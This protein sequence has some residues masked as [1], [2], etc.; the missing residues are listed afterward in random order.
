MAD[1]TLKSFLVALGFRIDT[2]GER[3]F[4]DTIGNATKR[5]AELGLGIEAMALAVVGATKRVANSFEDMYYMSSRIGSSVKDIGAFGYA[6]S[7]L[8]GSKEA[9][10]QTLEELGKKLRTIPGYAAQLRNR[11]IDPNQGAVA[12]AKEFIQKSTKGMSYWQSYMWAQNFSIDERTMR[13]AMDKNFNKFWDEYNEKIRRIGLDPKKAAEDAKGFDQAW[14]SLGVT[15]DIIGQK[16]TS[17]LFQG[18]GKDFKGFSDF[19]LENSGQ[20]T[21]AIVKLGDA[22]I[23]FSEAVVGLLT[24]G[25][26]SKFVD[27]LTGLVKWLSGGDEGGQSR[28]LTVFEG[29]LAA[30]VFSKLNMLIGLLDGVAVAVRGFTAAGLALAASPFGMALTALLASTTGL[31]EGEQADVDA[32]KGRGPGKNA[33]E[34]AKKGLLPGFGGKPAGKP[35]SFWQ[36]LHKRFGTLPPDQDPD[37][38]RGSEMSGGWPAGVSFGGENEPFYKSVLRALREWWSE[39]RG[40]ARLMRSGEKAAVAGAL[41]A[42]AAFVP[43]VMAGEVL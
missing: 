7:Q 28:L 9:A 41:A 33:A 13:A 38:P 23:K 24:T 11:G 39:A 19:L 5:V 18:L 26:L 37:M 21:D 4:L 16:V 32:G 27:L 35:L 17:G 43:C 12:I 20:I 22:L 1:E 36:R 42:V 15:F 8:G 25:G 14:R 34:D 40:W 30:W 29:L 2:Q 6:V 3:R 10:F 31:N